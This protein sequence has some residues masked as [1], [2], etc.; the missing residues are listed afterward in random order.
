M[1]I[2]IAGAPDA[3]AS[4]GAAEPTT[5]SRPSP[6]EV[7]GRQRPARTRRRRPNTLPYLLITPAVVALVVMLGY[8]LFRLGVLS[9]QKFGLRQQFGQPPEWVGLE[10]YRRILTDS[11]F[12]DVLWRTVIFAIVNVALTIGLGLL[13]ALLMRSLGRAM[14][15]LVSI[16]LMLAWAMPAL[17]ATVVWQWLFD[18]QYGLV[19][20]FFTTLGIGDYRGHSWLSEP[21]SFFMVATIIVVWMGIPFV[22]FTLFA[23]MTQIPK[24]VEE[25]AC[26]DGAGPWQ[27]FRDVTLSMIKPVLLI[28]TAL[29]ILWD[30]RVFTQIYVLQRAGGINRETNLLG[31]YAYRISIGENRFDV[32]AAIAV[33][34]VLITL[35]LTLVYLRQMVRQE[36]L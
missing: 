2:G 23:A 30:F 5:S 28:L 9:L 35:L 13:I 33:V 24:D 16:G 1:A 21:I 19:N 31:V 25:A 29:S 20:W 34:M 7:D 14:R 12:W 8:P 15:L 22:A 27:R 3:P 6:H 10:N 18:T 26:I 36:E 32:G 17:T 11:Y 4:T